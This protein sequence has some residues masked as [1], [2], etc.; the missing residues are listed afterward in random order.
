MLA[1]FPRY[2]AKL[3]YYASVKEVEPI[4]EIIKTVR[5]IKAKVGA[6]PSKRVTLFVKTE[7]KKAD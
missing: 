4:K 3:N 2:S 5:N 1:D 6:A 7:N